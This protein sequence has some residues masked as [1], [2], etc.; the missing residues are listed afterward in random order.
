[1]PSTA[2]QGLGNGQLSVVYASVLFSSLVLA[3]PLVETIG[4]PKHCLS[5]AMLG[6]MSYI[7]FN[8]YPSFYNTD[9]PASMIV[10]LC[11]AP[12]WASMAAYVWGNLISYLTLRTE[13]RPVNASSGS[14]FKCRTPVR[15]QFLSERLGI[16]ISYCQAD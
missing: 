4:P 14:K 10:G 11:S 5:F 1:A 15:Q 3:N 8:A 7:A 6:Y 16:G 2:Q 12:L 13:N 9:S